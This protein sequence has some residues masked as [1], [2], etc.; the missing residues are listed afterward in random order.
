MASRHKPGAASDSRNHRLNTT[1]T[2]NRSN[3]AMQI[4]NI[5]G[6]IGHGADIQLVTK[7]IADTGATDHLL[8]DRPSLQ[9]CR[10]SHKR[11]WDYSGTIV[12]QA[13]REGT[14]YLYAFNPNDIDEP[15]SAL[16]LA[17]STMKGITD[18]IISLPKIVKGMG[19][20][21]KLDGVDNGWEGLYRID[22]KGNEY[23]HIPLVWDDKAGLWFIHFSVV[24]NVPLAA[25]LLFR[26]TADNQHFYP[27]M[28]IAF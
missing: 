20:K 14:Q 2:L 15:G 8:K 28:L 16:A 3:S 1:G 21:C 17:A 7:A 11:F 22:D 4:A 9:F 23:G 25:Y 19:Y 27:S 18:D 24:R 10:K 12:K 6:K 5:K 13:C 26:L